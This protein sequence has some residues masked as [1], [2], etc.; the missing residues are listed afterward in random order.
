MALRALYL[1]GLNYLSEHNL[2]S[3]RRWKSGLDY[4]REVGRRS[5]GTPEITSAFSSNVDLFERG[6][7]SPR[8][9]DREMVEQFASG[10]SE[11][12]RNVERS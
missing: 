1:S 7:Y 12:R 5:R 2:V 10:L 11:I 6:W 9:A 8:G 3:I 4:R